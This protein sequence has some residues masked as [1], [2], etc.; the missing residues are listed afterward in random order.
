MKK[1]LVWLGRDILTELHENPPGWL[2]DR[3]NIISVERD[4]DEERWVDSFQFDIQGQPYLLNSEYIIAA[5][6]E[7][8]RVSAF[9][10]AANFCL[11]YC[12]VKKDYGYLDDFEYLVSDVAQMAAFGQVRFR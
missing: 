12:L 9:D 7:I 11:S 5:I 3:Y 8:V 1:E 2:T 4:D 6:K 10:E